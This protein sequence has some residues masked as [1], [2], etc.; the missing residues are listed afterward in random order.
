MQDKMYMT[1]LLDCYRNLLTDKQQ[2]IC[3]YYFEDDYSLQEICEITKTSRSAVYDLIRRTKQE[4]QHFE[5]CLKVYEQYVKRMA[6]YTK[7]L[8]LENPEVTSLIQQCITLEQY[9]EEKEHE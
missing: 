6:I 2:E 8:K 3:Q 7:L 5:D 1:M 4:L 9:E